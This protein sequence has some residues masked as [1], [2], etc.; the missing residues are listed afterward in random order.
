VH[1]MGGS[2]RSFLLGVT[3]GIA[4]GKT[5]VAEMIEELG[6]RT[7]D[8]D[9][10]SRTVV[11]PGKPAWTEIVDYFG[12]HI[13]RK[14]RSV[15]RKKLA[16]IVFENKEK[17]EQ[18]ERLLH[19]RIGEEFTRIVAEYTSRGPESVIQAVVPLL[20]E[21]DMQHLFDKVLVVYA[22]EEVQIERLMERDT[23]DCQSAAA[24]LA[25]QW[26]IE[27][28]KGLGHFVVD[29]SGSLDRTRAQIEDVWRHIDQIRTKRGP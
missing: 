18:L 1:V 9:V 14:D 29:N 24:M 3:G 25:S 7:I 16:D 12:E 8:F 15:D 28:K 22:P 20:F 17:R 4:T 23:I 21:T 19:P 5:V 10:L 2:D 13:L 26:P 11:E 27:K 6:A